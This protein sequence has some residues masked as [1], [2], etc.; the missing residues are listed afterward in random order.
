MIGVAE[1]ARRLPHR[2]PMLLIDRVIEI[3]PGERLTALKAVTASE[4]WFGTR[5][6]TDPG[7]ALDRSAMHFPPVLLM[8]SLCQAAALLAVWDRPDSTV[9]RKRAMLLGSVLEV[10]IHAPVEPGSVIH[11]RVRLSRDFGDS[12]VF[13]GTS[14]VDDEVVLR[15]GQV[16]VALRTA[17]AV[18]NGTK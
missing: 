17:T 16:L 7:I 5:P 9:L 4:P 13:E 6:P 2:Y 14:Y 12:F 11:H 1:I 8:E 10:T 3:V 15:I 18:S